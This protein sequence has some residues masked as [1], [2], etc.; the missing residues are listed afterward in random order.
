MTS[1]SSKVY[2]GQT[3]KISTI[4]TTADGEE[5]DAATVGTLSYESSNPEVASVDAQGT[6]T[7]N[8]EGSATITVTA[9]LKDVDMQGTP[10]SYTTST[11]FTVSCTNAKGRTCIHLR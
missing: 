5:M 3:D 10:V 11:S 7:Y 2:V 9:E 6:I 1:D 4:F 8:A